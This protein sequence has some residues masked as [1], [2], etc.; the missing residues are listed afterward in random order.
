MLG[1]VFFFRVDD[2]DYAFFERGGVL[3]VG[4]C[5]NGDKVPKSRFYRVS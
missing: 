1:E 5:R 3:E 2:P 4:R